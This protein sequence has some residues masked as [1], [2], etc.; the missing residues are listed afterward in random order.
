MDDVH[1]IEKFRR[2]IP[3]TPVFRGEVWPRNAKAEFGGRLPF[4]RG[5]LSA[6]HVGRTATAALERR[7][8]VRGS[9]RSVGDF[10]INVSAVP[11]RVHCCRSIAGPCHQA[12][13]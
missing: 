12:Q 6:T 10:S 1:A 11:R 5:P 9:F 3:I 4:R 8:A 13:P 7:E 2:T